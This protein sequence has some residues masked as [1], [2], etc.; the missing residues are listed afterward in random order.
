MKLV[1]LNTWGSAGPPERQRVLQKALRTLD[2]DLLCLQEVP[3]PNGFAQLRDW[4]F[5]LHATESGL[6]ILSRFP[7]VSHRIE[8][9]PTIS[10]FS[11]EKRQLLM[12]QVAVDRQMFWVANTH[13]A[14][15]KEEEPTRLGQVNDLVDLLSP[16]KG[17]IVLAGDFN[18]TCQEA[19][20]VRLT[21]S[22]WIDLFQ[23]FHPDQPG[24][25]WD[26]ANPFIRSHTVKFPN[27][28]IDYI[29]F[30]PGQ[31]NPLQPIACEVVCDTPDPNGLYPSDHYG[32]LATFDL[33][34]P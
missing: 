2:A 4:P 14:W 18:A 27:R 17:T 1:T 16:L 34:H 26:N 32:V 6:A 29:W 31:P 21:Q 5:C 24:W 23:R 20:I 30:H 10:P 25:T 22:G 3:D 28:R 8:T 15:K 19:S 9:Y 11:D 12:A 33:N 13:L 7:I